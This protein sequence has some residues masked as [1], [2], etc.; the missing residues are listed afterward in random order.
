MLVVQVHAI[1]ARYEAR[2]IVRVERDVIER[3][4]GPLHT[5]RFQMHNGP[6]AS[7]EPCSREGE[8]RAWAHLKS[9]HI[10]VER[11]GGVQIV[12]RDGDV[13]DAHGQLAMRTW[14]IQ[15][16]TSILGMRKG[17]S[18]RNLGLGVPRYLSQVPRPYRSST[19]TGVTSRGKR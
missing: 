7:V 18:L 9:E 2:E 6:P 13:V 4:I 1:K 5:W 12:C 11:N 8:R 16:R 10:A 17:Q 15:G 19:K 3:R 14:R